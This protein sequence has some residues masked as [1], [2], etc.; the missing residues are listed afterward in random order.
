[1][2]KYAFVVTAVLIVLGGVCVWTS[3]QNLN[4]IVLESEV[5]PESIS[6]PVQ[7]RKLP[8]TA[9]TEPAYE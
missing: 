4:E 1:M 5:I 7:P 8:Q 6:K 9:I 3:E 2:L